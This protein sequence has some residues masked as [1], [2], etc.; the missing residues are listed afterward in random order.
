M[1]PS[2]RELVHSPDQTESVVAACALS[3][4]DSE[5]LAEVVR[6]LSGAIIYKDGVLAGIAGSALLKIGVDEELAGRKICEQLPRM[7][8]DAQYGV[9]V[10]AKQLGTKAKIIFDVAGKLVND[11]KTAPAVRQVAASVLRSISAGSKKGYPRSPAGAA[12]A[13]VAG[14]GRRH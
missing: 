5:T 7:K 10:A 9:L 14:R 6:V 4:A 3:R 1:I 2:L 13:Q 8:E 11:P 12:F